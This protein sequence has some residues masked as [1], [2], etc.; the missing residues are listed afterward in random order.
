VESGGIGGQEDRR[1]LHVPDIGRY[2][3]PP[4]AIDRCFVRIYV[5]FLTRLQDK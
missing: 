2:R 5:S 3:L 4:R 1:R